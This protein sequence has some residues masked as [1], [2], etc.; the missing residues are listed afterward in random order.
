MSLLEKIT[1]GRKRRRRKTLLHGG[2]GVGKSTFANSKGT[3]FI[4]LAGDIDDID[5]QALKCRSYDS[6]NDETSFLNIMRFLHQGAHEYTGVTIDTVGE[7]E[8]LIHEYICK[9]HNISKIEDLEWQEGFKI[10][11]NYFRKVMNMLD[12]LRVERDMSVFLVAHSKIINYK[13]PT[14]DSYD[15]FVPDLHKDVWPELVKWCTDVFFMKFDV[16]T[17]SEDAGFGKKINKGLGAG[18]RILYTRERPAF[19]AKT[20][21]DNLPDEM[22]LNRETYDNYLTEFE[23]N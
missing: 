23:R 8:K 16:V 6:E 19:I 17:T 3:F 10:A 1:T 2:G 15:Q 4:D 13:D 11:A 18:E 21:I 5:C 12:C 9:D 20:R 14:R 7:L 22:P